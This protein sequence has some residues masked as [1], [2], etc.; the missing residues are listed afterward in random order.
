MLKP[1]AFKTS[2]PMY[3]IQKNPKREKK[4]KYML[5]F[6]FTSKSKSNSIISLG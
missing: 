1:A 2:V 6:L 5:A 3:L 4:R